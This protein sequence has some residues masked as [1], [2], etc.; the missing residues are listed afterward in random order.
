MQKWLYYK[1]FVRMEYPL[2]RSIG[3]LLQHVSIIA[4]KNSGSVWRHRSRLIWKST[5][6][7]Y[8]LKKKYRFGMSDNVRT[9][10][11]RRQ[12]L[13]TSV[14]QKGGKTSNCISQWLQEAV[15]LEYERR[16]LECHQ[17]TDDTSDYSCQNLV[18]DLHAS[19][20]LF[21]QRSW[22]NALQ[23]ILYWCY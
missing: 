19:L 5:C 10:I 12:T 3:K 17:T 20:R 4:W 1:L 6:I 2:N 7:I 18:L 21:K 15:C 14:M 22:V 11:C 16:I 13:G 9:D 23:C 8:I